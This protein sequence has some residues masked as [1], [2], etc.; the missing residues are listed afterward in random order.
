MDTGIISLW[1]ESADTWS[2]EAWRCLVV[3]NTA[4]LQAQRLLELK[5][6]V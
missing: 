4:S 6:A 2:A 5:L 1:L 3:N